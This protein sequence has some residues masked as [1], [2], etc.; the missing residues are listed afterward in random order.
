MTWLV[1]G[2]LCGGLFYLLLPSGAKHNL[3]INLIV[4][5]IGAI[6]AGIF[7]TP[8]FDVKT[9]NQRT[10]SLPSML[11]SLGGAV[12]LLLIVFLYG[13]MKTNPN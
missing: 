7:I 12:V 13:R 11:V 8:I 4:G 2:S 6:G 9:V 1:V 3:R 5:I 10:F